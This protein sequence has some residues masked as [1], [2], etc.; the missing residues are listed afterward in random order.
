MSSVFG[1]DFGSESVKIFSSK[2]NRISLEKNMIAVLKPNQVIAVGDQAFAM[3]DKNPPGIDVR[4]PVTDGMIDDL[5][6]A[7]FVLEKLVNRIDS[8]VGYAPVFYFSAPLNMSK[9][10][11][12][13]YV[14]ICEDLNVRNIRVFLVDQP[15]CDAI[16]LGIPINRTRGSMVVNIGDQTT[17]ISV[18]SG[19]QII[20][21][22]TIL[23]GG[24]S[25]NE[26]ICDIVR[27]NTN[28]RIGLRTADRLKRVL[29][30]CYFGKDA[31]RT[32]GMD[33]LSGV[34]SEVIITSEMVNEAVM[35]I[36]NVIAHEINVFLERIPPQ[37]AQYVRGEGFYIT[38]G[39]SR[40]RNIT[41]YI[42]KETGTKGNLSYHHEM[43]TINGIR[44]IIM[45]KDLQKLAY[46]ADA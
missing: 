43:S 16:A 9:I 11:K 42:E 3:F 31:R 45:Y 6:R 35:N 28:I 15:L 12:K 24:R 21:S 37:I 1:V 20:V 7:G 22:K 36:V 29:S 26:N 39:C 17:V 19:G 38:G 27:R 13:A 33:T 32:Y 25:I 44:E 34:P 2:K 10:E 4:S 46:T 5:D 40:I 14:D 23:L 8:G 18:I 30:D 41:E